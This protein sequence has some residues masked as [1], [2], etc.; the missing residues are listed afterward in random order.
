M[1]AFV[2]EYKVPGLYKVDA[3]VA[4]EVCEKLQA[5]PQGLSPQT[6]LDASRDEKAPLHEVFDWDDA[7]AAESYRLYQGRALICNLTVVVRED[8]RPIQP[9]RAFVCTPGGKSVYVSIKSALTNEKLRDHLI[10]Q[11]RQDARAFLSKYH[12]LQ[13]LTNVNEQLQMFLDETA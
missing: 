2:Y 7:K 13:E 4:G 6:L 11:A 3:Q 1:A 10:D 5:S 12:R 8:K 9:E